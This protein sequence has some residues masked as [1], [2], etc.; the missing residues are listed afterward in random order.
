MAERQVARGGGHLCHVPDILHT[1]PGSGLLFMFLNCAS[2]DR[3]RSCR[4]AKSELCCHARGAVNGS[5]GQEQTFIRL[6][7]LAR[8]TSWLPPHDLFAPSRTPNRAAVGAACQK[9][10]Q[11][12]W[13]CRPGRQELLCI[14]RFSSGLRVLNPVGA[15]ELGTT[16]ES[17][18]E[19]SDISCDNRLEAARADYDDRCRREAHACICF[20]VVTSE[21]VAAELIDTAVKLRSRITEEEVIC[22]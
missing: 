18:T 11:C 19:M 10:S 12:T 3:E 9:A 14:S 8:L 13:W 1:P 7:V 20:A 17:G 4:A 16:T 2:Y 5:L 21:S 22:S 6:S 15:Q